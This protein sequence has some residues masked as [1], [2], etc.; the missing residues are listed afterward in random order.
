LANY[1]TNYLMTGGYFWSDT[2]NAVV[3]TYIL[4]NEL[5]PGNPPDRIYEQGPCWN[6][7]YYSEYNMTRTI[8]R[9]VWGGGKYGFVNLA[10]H[11]SKY[12]V[13]FQE[14]HPTCSAQVYFYSPDDCAYLN[15][16][17]P[18]VV[19][20]NA[21]S[22]A[23][24]EVNNLGRRLLERGAVAFVGSTRIAF[25]AHG[26]NDVSDGN[27]SSVDYLF[28]KRAISLTGSR[29]S[30]GWSH[31][32]AMRD[33]YNL[34][35][36]DT[37]WWQ[38]FEWNLYGNPDL[39]I[40]E[41]PSTLP[42]LTDVTPTG[43]SFPIVPRSV[44]GASSGSCAV[45]STLPGNTN[46]T[47]F[48][49]AWTNDGSHKTPV[50]W[51]KVYLDGDLYFTTSQLLD[52][53]QV[54]SRLN[55]Q[56]SR[57]ITG[58]R[59]TMHYELDT[60]E[61]V[62]ETN[63]S[64]NCW[65]HQFVWSPKAL[66]DDA[67]VTRLAPPK[68]DGWGCAPLPHYYNNDGFS[69][70]VQNA[71]P[72]KWMS[73]VGILPSSTSANYDLRL[74]NRNDY[75]GSEGGFGAGHL[76][77][78]QEPTGKIDF[79][80][81]ND[82]QIQ[83][84][85]YYAGAINWNAHTAG[86][87]IE[88]DTSVPIYKGTNGPYYKA[89]HNVLDVYVIYLS[90][91]GD[92]IFKLEQLSGDCDLGMSIYNHNTT[93]CKKSE[94]L[95]SA[96]AYG[97][98]GD[99]SFTV[100]VPLYGYYGLVVWKVDASD[101]SKDGSYQIKIGECINPSVPSNPSPADK[102]VNVSINADLDWD[103]CT[104][105][106]HYEVW[107]GEY[108]STLTKLGD[109]D[110]SEWNLDPLDYNTTYQW[111]VRAYNICDEYTTSRFW[112]F[113]TAA[114]IVPKITV[115]VPNGGE[116]WYL[117]NNYNIRW[118]SE[119]HTG[120][121]AIKISTSGGLLWSTITNSTKD[122]GIYLWTASAKAPSSR[123]LIQ[124]SSVADPS[125][126]DR[127]NRYFTLAESHI[128]VTRPNGGEVWY[129]GDTEE[130]TWK[131]AGAEKY[132]KIEYITH[133]GVWYTIEDSAKNIGSYLWDIK[134]K[135]SKECLV[136]ISDSNLSDESDSFF[137]ILQRNI[138]VKTPNGGEVWFVGD[139]K[140]IA[141]TSSYVPGNVKIDISRNNGLIW[142]V[143]AASTAND[144]SYEWKVIDPTSVNCRVRVSSLS[145][146]D[147]SD[148]SNTAFFIGYE[149]K[150]DADGSYYI[151]KNDLLMLVKNWLHSEDRPCDIIGDFDE[152]CVV[153]LRDF[154]ILSSEWMLSSF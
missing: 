40:T 116:V 39:W 24:P 112:T 93:Y 102:A 107:M 152:N 108:G 114:A 92:Y 70:L 145:Y 45:T 69:F 32:R 10:G 135:V 78:S 80:L 38:F 129:S 52:A 123:C 115:T 62:W 98:G 113:T 2:D 111:Y 63:E 139:V 151:D 82:Y 31:Q 81:L 73:A 64:D 68:K 36:F 33:M 133:E 106:D 59:H 103:D 110:V 118:T 96:N 16:D 6:S 87:R 125:V 42:N 153:D 19:F 54:A 141:W 20:S 148:R 137:A 109:T 41:R 13:Y 12:G 23:Y 18:S 4:N 86:Y 75:T 99:E 21:C 150:S 50:N 134:S 76:E 143:I 11:G 35:G 79:V 117:G 149:L 122:D 7:S 5:D 61:E 60:E 95:A 83:A 126:N 119:N 136:R 37:S 17:Y 91:A 105:V 147:V 77:W 127:S 22:T 1:K 3:K 30:V 142:S 144:G 71:H 58:G 51:M 140:K 49:W 65:G 121:V 132:V 85:T 48:N 29:S 15:D 128:T 9:S 55:L 25:G 101:Y 57:T 124:V 74:W 53:G 28:C 138:T 46:N 90:G 97:D 56:G 34:Y 88:E 26:W 72:N 67:P 89:S 27:C 104:D 47:Y 100:T 131:S 66:S 8:T 130:I 44:G 84:G 43:W 94:S 146:P 154:E 14:R 120:S